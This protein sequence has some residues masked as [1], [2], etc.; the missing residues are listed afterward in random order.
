MSALCMVIFNAL[1]FD[2]SVA[3]SASVSGLLINGGGGLSAVDA[4]GGEAVAD[5][6][7]RIPVDDMRIDGDVRFCGNAIDGILDDAD[8]DVGIGTGGGK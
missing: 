7:K 1:S 6:A 3:A 2:K 5:D 4:P 8:V